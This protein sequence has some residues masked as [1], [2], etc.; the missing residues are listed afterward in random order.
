MKPHGHEVYACQL[1][2]SRVLTEDCTITDVKEKLNAKQNQFP[3]LKLVM[4]VLDLQLVSPSSRSLGVHGISVSI[5]LVP[6]SFPQILVE[7][8]FLSGYCLN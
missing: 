8:D 5:L 7:L 2:E 3:F 4:A 6:S 1:E